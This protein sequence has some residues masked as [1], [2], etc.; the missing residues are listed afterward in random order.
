MTMTKEHK[1][2]LAQGRQEGRAVRVYLEALE[3]NKPKRGRKRTRETA[4]QQL[5]DVN[6]ELESGELGAV[7][8]LEAIQ[9]RNDLTAELNE[10][11]DEVD[12]AALEAGFIA[13]AA[14]YAERKGLTYAAFR[15][16]GVPVSVLKEAGVPR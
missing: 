1:A 2:A 9:R 12:M 13:A 8:R 6:A 4:E 5:A 16:V 10:V 7:E 15:E 3:A 14:G 11:D